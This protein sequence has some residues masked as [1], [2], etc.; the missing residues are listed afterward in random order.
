[1]QFERVFRSSLLCKLKTC[2]RAGI[3]HDTDEMPDVGR[4]KVSPA[5]RPDLLRNPPLD[6]RQQRQ[7]R[8]AS[9]QALLECPHVPDLIADDWKA[10]VVQQ[11]HQNSPGCASGHGAIIFIHDL[12]VHRIVVNVEAARHALASDV[13]AFAAAVFIVN[14]GAEYAAQGPPV[15]ILYR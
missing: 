15:F 6:S 14:P 7:W 13:G 9:A 3:V 12:E 5:G 1:M 10:S 8:P 4:S 11:G 2:E